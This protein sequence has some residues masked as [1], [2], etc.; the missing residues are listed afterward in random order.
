MLSRVP[1]SAA[2]DTHKFYYQILWRSN[3]YSV[4][5]ICRTA[6]GDAPAIIGVRS[7]RGA[8]HPSTMRDSSTHAGSPSSSLTAALLADRHQRHP[9]PSSMVPTRPLMAGEFE[10]SISAHSAT[11]MLDPSSGTSLTASSSFLVGS[12]WGMGR[13]GGVFMRAAPGPAGGNFSA[14]QS[15]DGIREA[16]AE[17]PP[18]SSP[19][20]P[21][22][23]FLQ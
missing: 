2:T 9:T 19:Q 14:R 7:S 21:L 12:P 13:G 15:M 22:P 5:Q 11:S 6:A 10:T 17:V 3:T 4:P 23:A 16:R 1:D 8:S 20:Q 18:L